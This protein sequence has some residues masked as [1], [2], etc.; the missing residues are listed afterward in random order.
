[1]KKDPATEPRIRG[2]RDKEAGEG[3]ED[4][5]VVDSKGKRDRKLGKIQ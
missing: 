3:V 1:M 2:V 5:R 4:D